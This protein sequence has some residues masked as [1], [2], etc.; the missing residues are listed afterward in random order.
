M[1]KKKLVVFGLERNPFNDNLFAALQASYFDV[2]VNYILHGR[3][4]KN[5]TSWAKFEKAHY[6][7]RNVT[8]FATLDVVLT[9]LKSPQSVFIFTGYAKVSFIVGMMLCIILRKKYLV[10]S[11]VLPFKIKKS[12]FLKVLKSVAHWLAFHKSFGVLTTG[13]PGRDALIELGCHPTKIVNY[14]YTPRVKN[15]NGLSAKA[16]NKIKVSDVVP[17]ILVSGQLI[18]RK[19]VDLM[20]YALS[21]LKARNVDVECFIE[22]DGPALDFI[23]DLSV[24]L[25]VQDRVF[26][27]GF[28]EPDLH[29]ALLTSV[30]I[31]V[32]PSRWDPWGNIIPEAMSAGKVVIASSAV[33]SGRDRI[34]HGV[35]GL[36]FT[37]DNPMELVNCLCAVIVDKDFSTKLA[38]AACGS[39][40]IWTADFNAISLASFLN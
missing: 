31:V 13:K 19:G 40:D 32:S 6:F 7:A 28:N 38:D 2:N 11:D 12:F 4:L 33:E 20:I 21:K 29:S 35:N 18:Q 23:K 34:V 26:F 37:V 14:P 30:D 24:R 27:T 10:F 17:S 3:A 1:K 25:D 39:A 9:V 15:P 36:I 16:L 8:K 22:G 5:N